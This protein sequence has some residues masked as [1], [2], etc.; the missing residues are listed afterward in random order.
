[1]LKEQGGV[2]VHQNRTSKDSIVEHPAYAVVFLIH[3]LAYDREFPLN[4]SEK[5]SSSAGFWRYFP[6][7]DVWI[8]LC[9]LEAFNHDLRCSFVCWQPSCCDVERA[10]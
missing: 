4:F 2:S 10:G 8:P 7:S 9:K 5:D 1:V 6:I 3:S